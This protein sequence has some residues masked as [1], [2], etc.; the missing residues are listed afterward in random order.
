[1]IEG[2]GAGPGSGFGSGLEDP[3]PGP[4]GP[5]T[6]FKVLQ[7]FFIYLFQLI[8]MQVRIPPYPGVDHVGKPLPTCHL[9]DTTKPNLVIFSIKAMFDSK[10]TYELRGTSTKK[11]SPIGK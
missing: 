10:C 3:D 7:I 9:A 6:G 1:M 4:E 2:S 11:A 5:K 8:F